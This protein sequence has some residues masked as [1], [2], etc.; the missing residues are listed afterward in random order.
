[1]DD[2]SDHSATDVDTDDSDNYIDKFALENKQRGVDGRGRGRGHGGQGRGPTA[3]H[4][5]ETNCRRGRGCGRGKGRGVNARNRAPPVIT[6][7][8]LE[9]NEA[10]ENSNSL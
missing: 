9:N 10:F 2:I 6:W 3:G 1:M 7:K 8:N 4:K 5:L